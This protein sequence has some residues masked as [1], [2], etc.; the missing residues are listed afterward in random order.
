MG[1]DSDVIRD[2]DMDINEED[3]VAS[4]LPKCKTC[5]RYTYGH[6]APVGPKC[7]L[8]RLREEEIDA[9]NLVTIEKRKK[10]VRENRDS[11]FEE[12]TEGEQNETG[13]GSGQRSASTSSTLQI[14]QQNLMQSML[15]MMQPM[16]T[17]QNTQHQQQ[18]ERIQQNNK[19]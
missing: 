5:G 14:D 4:R 9:E 6:A 8:K 7:N 17:Q 16:L 3:I 12:N 15:L 11:V 18:I 13:S 2:E 19:S 10:T 1:K